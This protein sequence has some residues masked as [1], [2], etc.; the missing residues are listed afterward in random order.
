MKNNNFNHQ[1]FLISDIMPKREVHLICGPSGVGKT[2]FTLAGLKE[3]QKGGVWLDRAIPH[4]VEVFYISID[5]GRSSVKRALDRHKIPHDSFHWAA[6]DDVPP[7]TSGNRTYD[8]LSWIHSTH[9]LVE[10]VLIDGFASLLGDDHSSYQKVADFLTGCQHLCLKYNLTILGSVHSP[11]LRVDEYIPN[12][13]QQVLGSVAWPGFTDLI[14][15]LQPEE[16]DNPENPNRICMVLPRDAAEYVL[17]YRNEGGILVPIPKESQTEDAK[18]AE[19]EIELAAPGAVW[20]TQQLRDMCNL[21]KT[22]FH[23]WLAL[24]V[25]SGLLTKVSRGTYQRF[26]AETVQ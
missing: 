16:P 2:N 25:A 5:R 6:R 11:K 18:R 8:I 1:E 17:N 12:P 14:I 26:G 4:A 21:P 3:L 24:A 15:G 10:F 19:S 7:G 22:S 9:P 13:R 23:R 20:T